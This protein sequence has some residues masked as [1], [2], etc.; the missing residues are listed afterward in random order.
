MGLD[1]L[2]NGKVTTDGICRYLVA[3]RVC[4]NIA[5]PVDVAPDGVAESAQPAGLPARDR[6]VTSDRVVFEVSIGRCQ[7]LGYEATAGAAA[8]AQ[9]D[10]V[11]DGGHMNHYS[12]STDGP[13]VSTDRV[14]GRN[15]QGDVLDRSGR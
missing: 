9:G 10:V 8:T 3:V 4:S 11:T 2:Q 13:Q 14:Y 6:E 5:V 15:V 12:Q 1:C 7:E